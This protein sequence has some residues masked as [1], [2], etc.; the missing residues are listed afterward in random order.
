VLRRLGLV[1]EQTLLVDVSSDGAI[2]LRQA[3]VYPLE[4]YSE[5]RLREFEESDRMSAGE[6]VRLGR[7]LKARR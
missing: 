4:I 2:V 7:K 5:A 1:G 6:K 3:G